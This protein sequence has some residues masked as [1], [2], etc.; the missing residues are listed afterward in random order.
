[1]SI[2]TS[3]PDIEALLIAG[4]SSVEATVNVRTNRRR[5]LVVRADL[6]Q[7]VTPISRYCRVGLSAWSLRPDGSSDL[8][9]A[10]DLAA[11]GNAWLENNTTGVVLSADVESG[12]SRVTD[13]VTKLEYLYS[14]VLLEVAV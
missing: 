2:P 12:P 3:S 8:G 11:A 14:T 5:E 1:M 4:L 7:K 10:F 13:P 6:Q 9:D